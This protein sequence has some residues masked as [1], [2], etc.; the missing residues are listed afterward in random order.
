MLARECFWVAIKL[1]FIRHNGSSSSLLGP[2]SLCWWH[3]E[4]SRD[5]CRFLSLL[6]S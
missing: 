6:A 2:S 1:W 3:W 5:V 4:V